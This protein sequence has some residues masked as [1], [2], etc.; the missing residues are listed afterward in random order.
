MT[1]FWPKVFLERKCHFVKLK[2]QFSEVVHMQKEMEKRS[3]QTSKQ[4]KHSFRH[5]LICHNFVLKGFRFIL[6]VLK[7]SKPKCCNRAKC[8]LHPLLILF[9]FIIILELASNW[10]SIFCPALVVYSIW[11]SWRQRLLNWKVFRE[12]KFSVSASALSSWTLYGCS[13]RQ[14][15]TTCSIPPCTPAPRSFCGILVLS[16]A[17]Y[18][19]INYFQTFQVSLDGLLWILVLESV[20]VCGLI[21]CSSSHTDALNVGSRAAL[22]QQING[23]MQHCLW[24]QSN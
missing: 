13:I 6:K 22:S 3:T 14:C 16:F 17:H 8:L 12:K 10:R 23:R 15:M 1:S 18:K 20:Y 5:L 19:S 11:M 2:C 9:F 21:I 7:G 4:K 24:K